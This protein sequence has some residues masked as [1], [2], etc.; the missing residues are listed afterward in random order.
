MDILRSYQQGSGQMVN[1]AK[2]AIFF[3]SKC[4]DQMKVDMKTTTGILTEALFEKY[5]GLPT[6]VGRSTKED[7]E[8]IPGKIS[9]L[10]GGMG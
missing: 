8:Y 7:F 2:S 4:D 1:M 6:A 5:L 10:M 9:D 3:S